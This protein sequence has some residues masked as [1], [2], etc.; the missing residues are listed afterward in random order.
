VADATLVLIRHAESTWNSERRWQ[1]WG[2]P[3]LSERGLEQAQALARA[4]AGEEIDALF[5]SDLLRAIQTAEPLARALGRQ[6]SPDR[7]LRE[8]DIGAWTGLTREE[9][10]ACDAP[11]LESFSSG[12]FHVRAPDGE[13]RDELRRRV[14][15][16]VAELVRAHPGGRLALVTH[17]GVIGIL[18][19]GWRP[20]NAEWCQI[21][22]SQLENS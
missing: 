17:R 5:T 2:D 13:S 3:P 9:I 21:D 6:A 8:L 12:D 14:H 11:I 10:S 19:P 20:G 4:L 22:A 18:R 15:E 7:A 16:R 1:G